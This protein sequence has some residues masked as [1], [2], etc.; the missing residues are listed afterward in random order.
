MLDHDDYLPAYVLISQAT[1]H[2]AK[3]LGLLRLNA[4]SIVAMDRAYN[5][6]RQFARW[7]DTGV[8]FVTRMKDNAVYAVV[9]ERDVP[10]HRNIHSDAIILLTGPQAQSK[11]PHLLRRIVVW[12]AEHE[13]EIVLLTNHLDFGATT[14]AG[15]YKE[16]WQIELFFKA[17]KQ[18][19]RVKSFVGT[20]ENALRIQIWT[21]L[22]ALFLCGA[23]KWLDTTSR[24]RGGRSP[25]LP[26]CC[27]STSLPTVICATGL[28]TPSTHRH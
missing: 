1:M 13:R 18:N 5:D 14:V 10:V 6:Y 8:Y 9:D 11:C 25:I 12:D 15:I 16:R 22:L 20:T 2:D 27:A 23:F 24:Q 19:L 21:A 3:V 17:L 26:P 28:T 7:T 4:G